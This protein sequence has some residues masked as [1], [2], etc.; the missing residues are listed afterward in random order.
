MIRP[1]KQVVEFKSE[2]DMIKFYA[3]N[4]DEVI[5]EKVDDG[6]E[7]REMARLYLEDPNKFDFEK[8]DLH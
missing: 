4:F 8:E 1:E 7:I 6:D 5:W 3:E 2:E